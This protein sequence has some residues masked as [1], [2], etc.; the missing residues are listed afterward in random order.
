MEITSKDRQMAIDYKKSV[1]GRFMLVEGAKI[2]SRVTGNDLCVTRK[3]D[4]HMQCL[5]YR[6]GEA[7]MLNSGGNEKASS[8]KCID[9]FK[10]CMQRAAVEQAVVVAELYMPRPQGRPRCGD[11]PTALADEQRRNSLSLAAFDILE[12]NGVPFK[13]SHYRDTHSL[14]SQWFD[15]SWIMPVEM[16]HATSLEE[17]SDIYHQWVEEEN[18]EGLVVH[19][20]SNIIYK[21]KP[22]HSIDAAIVGYTTGGAGVRDLMFAVRHPDGAYQV[23]AFGSRGMTDE[24]RQSLLN[25]LIDNHVAS[26]YVVADSRGVAYQMVKPSI[27]MEVS[28]IELVAKGNDEKPKRNGIITYDENNGWNVERMANGVSALGLVI[29][30][31][32]EDK[33]PVIDD[34]RVSQI[35]DLCPFE[36]ES[37]TAVPTAPSTILERRV[38]IKTLGDKKMLHKFLIW[39]TNKSGTGLFPAYVFYHTDYSSSRKDMLKRDMAFSST[40]E[41]IREIMANNI[42]SNVKKG[43]Q[44]IS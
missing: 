42:A 2:G 26:Q 6:E 5:F 1:A 21:V 23:F 11:V 3:I 24:Q 27:V 25:R 15:S 4:G 10:K 13:P 14:L 20:E 28:V 36:E 34:V 39:R 43:W 31:E 9:E 7:F 8:L 30:R 40:E 29:N 12:I 19:C 41:Q 44:E 16:R 18:A 33:T 22:R 35:T 17:V 37:N 32:R 38:F